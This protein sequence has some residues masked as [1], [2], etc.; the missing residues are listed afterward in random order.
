MKILSGTPTPGQNG[1]RSN[2]NERVLYIPQRS[3]TGV[4]PSD[5]LVSYPGYLW[6]VPLFRGAVGVFCSPNLTE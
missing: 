6:W 3:W 2:S 1:P 4:S 5:D